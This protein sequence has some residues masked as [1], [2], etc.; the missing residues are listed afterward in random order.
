MILD[1]S[2]HKDRMTIADIADALGISKTT[3]SRAIS[4]KGRIGE[5]TRQKVLGF[6][7]ENNYRPNPLAKGLANSKTYNLC[8]AIPDDSTVTDAP[9][10]LRCTVGMAKEAAPM[11]YDILMVMMHGG[12]ISQLRR[13][14][15]NRKAD[16]VILGRTLVDDVGIAFL[17]ESGIPF[18]VIGST[19]AKDVVQIDNEHVTACEELTLAIREKGVKKIALIGGDMTHVVN[20][21]RKHGFEWG[22][23]GMD[24]KDILYY[25]DCKEN[26]DIWQ[27]V[28]D[29]L[30]RQTECLVCMDD[31]ICYHALLK[32][33]E[34][35]ISIPAQMKIASFYDSQLISNQEPP[36]TALQYDPKELGAVSCRT[37]LKMIE[38]EDVQE[39]TFLDYQLNITDS[40]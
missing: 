22:V 39:K 2:V 16:G 24:P 36:V 1:I 40:I 10:F 3:V 20:Q 25:L 32:L 37:L 29:A 15:E 31:R 18:V 11:D 21:T 28:S 17:K 14:V 30:R 6:I 12:N 26:E 38:G 35:H 8:F 27:A 34:E 19:E 33:R 7:E 13:V 4:G 5:Q 9:F 23:K